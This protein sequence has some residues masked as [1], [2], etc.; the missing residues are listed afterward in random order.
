MVFGDERF[1][2]R[3]LA[4]AQG[5]DAAVTV[6]I[7]AVGLARVDMGDDRLGTALRVELGVEHAFGFEELELAGA[8]FGHVQPRLPEQ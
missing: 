6:G 7:G 3:G 5:R 4:A 8:A 2:M 1:G